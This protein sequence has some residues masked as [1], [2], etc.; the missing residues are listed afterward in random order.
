[1]GRRS[2]RLGPVLD[3]VVVE[4]ICLAGLV[5]V[6]AAVYGAVVLGIGR[7]PT[8]DQR[9]LLAF[10]IVA[11]AVTA[12]LWVPLRTRLSVFAQRLVQD[13]RGQRDEVLR[14]FGSRLTQAIPLDEL[15]LQLA[16]SLRS[17]LALDSAEIWT[18]AGGLLERAASDPDA[19]GANLVLT[20]AEEATLARTGVVG[21]AW[22]R[23]WLPQ[24]ATGHDAAEVRA[25]AVAHSGELL[26]MIRIE[27]SPEAA[28]FDDEDERLL[29]ALAEQVGLALHN[30]RLGSA[31]QASLDELRRQADELR[32]S[33]ARVVTAADAERRRIER[34]LHDGAQQHLV[35]LA[36]NLRLARELAGTDPDASRAVLE[37]LSND[38]RDALDDFRDLAHG[39]YPPLLVD[40]GLAEACAPPY[41]ARVCRPESTRRLSPATRRRSRPRSTSAASRPSRTWPSTRVPVHARRSGSGRREVEF[42]LRSWTTATASTPM[43][44]REAPDSRT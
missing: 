15:L 37:E 35:A 39:I 34:D 20:P 27:R 29:A 42:A 26:G 23:V 44:R 10:S 13:E 2:P 43:R 4:A 12:L 24:L 7:V 17:A 16:E 5:G 33:R 25:A 21:A 38:V 11:A 36:V 18:G 32:V 30:V 19:G 6:V 9:T 40:R 14:T 41:R 28:P 8:S 1:M 3:R 22:L 31:L